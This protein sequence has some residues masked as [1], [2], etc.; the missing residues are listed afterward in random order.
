[1]ST[2]FDSDTSNN[3]AQTSGRC[4]GQILSQSAPESVLYE[5]TATDPAR[6]TLKLAIINTGDEQVEIRRIRPLIGQPFQ[7]DPVRI[8]SIRPV[9]PRLPRTIE[10]GKGA[11][12][13][14]RTLVPAGSPVATAQRPY[15]RIQLRCLD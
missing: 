4:R 15:F 9:T 5:P 14:V 1:V 12:F 11:V 6:Q 2:T 7:I 3:V 13:R 8:G 10:P